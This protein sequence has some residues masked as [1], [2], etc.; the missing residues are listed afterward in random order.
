MTDAETTVLYALSKFAQTCAA[1]VGAVGLF[2][3]QLLRMEA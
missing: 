3:L 2:K 1:L